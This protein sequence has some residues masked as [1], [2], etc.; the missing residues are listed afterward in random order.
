M[1]SS[2]PVIINHRTAVWNREA[3]YLLV[4]G[5]M[6]GIFLFIIFRPRYF[7]NATIPPCKQADLLTSYAKK[8]MVRIKSERCP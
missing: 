7:F 5:I 4:F 1:M 2:S 3:I 8:A 6:G